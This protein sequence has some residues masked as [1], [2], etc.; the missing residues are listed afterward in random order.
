[1]FRSRTNRHFI[2]PRTLCS[3]SQSTLVYRAHVWRCIQKAPTQEG[4]VRAGLT[5]ETALQESYLTSGT[6]AKHTGN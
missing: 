4:S 3:E 5:Y 6:T 2:L 1:M